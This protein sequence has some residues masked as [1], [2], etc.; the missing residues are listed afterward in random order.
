[1]NSPAFDALEALHD[2]PLLQIACGLDH[3]MLLV[4]S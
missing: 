4:K 3:T 1:M 2:C